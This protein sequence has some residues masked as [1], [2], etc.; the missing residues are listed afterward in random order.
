MIS[1]NDPTIVNFLVRQVRQRYFNFVLQYGEDDIRTKKLGQRSAQQAKALWDRLP[2]P[3]PPIHPIYRTDYA[4]MGLP[5]IRMFMQSTPV[6]VLLPM[7]VTG[8]VLNPPAL[9]PTFTF[10]LIT[11]PLLL[12][13]NWPWQ[14]D[15]SE[16]ARAQ[17][18][19]DQMSREELLAFLAEPGDVSK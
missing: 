3:T 8:M 16:E 19:V 4:Q 14:Y 5:G 6:K 7:S 11:N 1:G 15:Y 13:R 12:M 17:E 10:E 18:E 2:K 9:F